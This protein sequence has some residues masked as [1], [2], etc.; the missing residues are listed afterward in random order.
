ML[1]YK[2]WRPCKLSCLTHLWGPGRAVF[3]YLGS[4]IQASATI[5]FEV[6][7]GLS[8]PTLPV[9][10]HDDDP[11][12]R[13]RRVKGATSLRIFGLAPFALALHIFLPRNARSIVPLETCTDRHQGHSKEIGS[14]NASLSRTFARVNSKAVHFRHHT[15]KSII[16]CASSASIEPLLHFSHKKHLNGK[17][18]GG[19]KLHNGGCGSFAN[20]I[21]ISH[22]PGSWHA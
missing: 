13:I 22:H 5:A 1:S 21:T 9:V 17:R 11:H 2:S 7:R 19:I 15:V 3:P 20:R 18:D 14:S 8:T 12:S 10:L 4:S 16:Y 6:I